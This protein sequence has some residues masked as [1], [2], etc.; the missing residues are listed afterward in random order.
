VA[1]PGAAHVPVAAYPATAA[2]P[3][4]AGDS[5][6]GAFAAGLALG[7]DP[8]GAARRGCATAA[9][10]IGASGSLRLLD[11][12]QLAHD[13][14]TPPPDGGAADT[15]TAVAGADY[16]IG[17]MRREIATIPGAI[18]DHLA[19]P[20]G[21]VAQLAEWLAGRQIEHLYLTG[22]GDS[23]FAALASSLAFRR[24]SQ[25]TI[26]PVH[27]LDFARYLV[28]YL[29]PASAV[30]AISF[31][32]KAGRSVEAARQA[33]AF[34]HPVIGLTHNAEG[35]LA[36]AADRILPID[37]PTLG[38]SPGT[39]TYIAMLCTLV[40]LALRTSRAG[41]ADGVRAAC[42]E[43]PG[44]AAKTLGWC[45][46]LAAEAAA[47]IAPARFV[48]EWAH[49]EYFITR[50]G[51]PVVVVAPAGAAHDRA[52]EI[53][54]ELSFLGADVTVI[55][56]VEPPGPTTHLRLPVGVPEEL[57]PVLTALPLAQLGFHLARRAGKRS[58]NFPSEQAKNE[59]YATIHRATMGEP[60]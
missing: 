15:G 41:G 12:G 54:S 24:H 28:R 60:A 9:A 56:D 21:H 10:A 17:V 49:E 43:L 19:D 40:D 36:A 55:S 11:R 3:T 16:D 18:A 58:Y 2:D 4:G 32:G 45:D 8:A 44:Q 50:A 46:A 47:R 34:G 27:A 30:L 5:F 42:G 53:L 14:L 37:V 33:S 22:C 26:H 57:S 39:S 7:D 20:G 1:R 6:C 48:E 51:D 38:F 25:L 35:P 52:G 13:L 31:S 59:H 23:A 29:P